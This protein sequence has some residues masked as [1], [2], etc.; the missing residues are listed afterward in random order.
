MPKEIRNPEMP[1]TR[2][3]LISRL[4]D[5]DEG[6][7]RAALDE[8]CRA[9]HY[10]LYCQIRRHGLA[11]HDAEDALQEFL[12]KL[13]RLD[14][15]VAADEERGRLRTFLRVSLR[16][17]LATWHRDRLRKGT[18][19]V[20]GDLL[21]VMAGL[22]HRFLLDRAAHHESPDRLYDRQWAQELM[23]RVLERLRERYALKGR[24]VTFEA[25]RPGLLNGG[26]LAGLKT[27]E[28]SARLGVS[29][30]SLRTAFHRLLEDFRDELRQEILQTV[31]NP[32]LAK[33]EYDELLGLFVGE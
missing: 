2:W 33:Q 30:G 1:T 32:G 5:A 3:S 25:L 14:T 12:F 26:S 23:N 16:R 19:Q 31:E 22:E 15:F 28:L 21:A 11:H 13:V 18:R 20:S 4:K 24:S 10:P 9:Y 27:E 6:T 17:F 8:I 29:H 7:A